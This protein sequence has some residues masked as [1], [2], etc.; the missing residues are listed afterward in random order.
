M[1]TIM[2]L[3]D[4]QREFPKY[5]MFELDYFHACGL[6]M[7]N[8]FGEQADAKSRSLL[9]LLQCIFCVLLALLL[10]EWS[11]CQ[12]MVQLSISLYTDR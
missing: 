8:V 10:N 6:A 7:P 11:S 9:F 4:V 2:S 3:A 5:A 12:R 1:I